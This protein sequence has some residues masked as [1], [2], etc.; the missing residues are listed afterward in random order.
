M[1]PLAPLEAYQEGIRAIS[2]ARL[3][4]RSGLLFA[5]L[6]CPGMAGVSLWASPGQPIPWRLL[7]VVSLFT[8]ALFGLFFPLGLKRSLLRTA[9]A[10]YRGQPPYS[11]TAP[12][13]R[14]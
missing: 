10:V 5:L 4:L 1:T 8:G 13:R 11:T 14:F 9:E 12:D 7:A 3:G 6:F 2:S